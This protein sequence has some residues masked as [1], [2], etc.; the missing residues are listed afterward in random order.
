MLLWLRFRGHR[1]EKYCCGKGFVRIDFEHVA[2]ANVSWLSICKMLLWLR[3]WECQNRR[4]RSRLTPV[5][6]NRSPEVCKIPRTGGAGTPERVGRGYCLSGFNISYQLS[7]VSYQL[8]DQLTVVRGGLYTPLGRW[9]RRIWVK[10]GGWYEWA[11]NAAVALVWGTL[12]PDM[13]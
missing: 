7:V 1:L 9:P 12:R 4:Q 13:L 10:H 3:L 11:R 8:A 5:Q 6:R 2:V